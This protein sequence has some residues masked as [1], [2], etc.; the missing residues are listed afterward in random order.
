MKWNLIKIQGDRNGP[1]N[2]FVAVNMLS[3]SAYNHRKGGT[4]TY[5]QLNELIQK[6]IE[7]IRIQYLTSDMPFNEYLIR[8]AQLIESRTFY[9]ER[10]RGMT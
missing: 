6:R 2:S 9:I 5:H 1:L 4:M 10:S 3:D 8:V 7:N